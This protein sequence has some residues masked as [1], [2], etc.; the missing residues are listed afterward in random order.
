MKKRSFQAPWF[1]HFKWLHY[2]EDMDAAFC[3]VCAKA[4]DT[5]RLSG[6]AQGMQLF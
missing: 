3:H 2:D 5:G 4:E 1:D 6:S